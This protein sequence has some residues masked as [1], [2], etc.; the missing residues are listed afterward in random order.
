MSMKHLAL[1]HWFD[2]IFV[3]SVNA[4]FQHRLPALPTTAEW[5]ALSDSGMFVFE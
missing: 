4:I 2:T 5:V 1:E 3:L